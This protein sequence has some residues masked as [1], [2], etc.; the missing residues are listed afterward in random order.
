MEAKFIR[1]TIGILRGPGNLLRIIE[2]SNYWSVRS[3]TVI[4]KIG[5]PDRLFFWHSKQVNEHIVCG[6]L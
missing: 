5:Q 6:Y 2:I 3:V 1:V 4:K